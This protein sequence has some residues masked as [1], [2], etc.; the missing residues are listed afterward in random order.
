MISY[1]KYA[2]IRDIKGLK[3]VHIAK[4]AHIS[5]AT[6]SEWKKGTYEPKLETMQKIAAVLGVSFAELIEDEAKFPALNQ[7]VTPKTDRELFNEELLRLY[8]N[9]TPD[10]QS[11]VMTLLK[12]SQKEAKLP[13]LKG[14]K[15]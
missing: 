7:L 1:E 10:A 11:A 3:D 6:L 8:H 5:P 9:A 12:N 15:I 14:V 13:V 4:E 2:R